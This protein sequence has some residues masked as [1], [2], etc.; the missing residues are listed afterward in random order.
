MRFRACM[1]IVVLAGLIV[2]SAGLL[3]AHHSIANFW[4]QDK[5]ISISGVVT[6]VKLVN[7][8]PEL[9]IDVTEGGQ[10]VQYVAFLRAG[11]AGL[12]KLGLDKAAFAPGT[13][14][15]LDGHPPKAGKGKGIFVEALTLGS[16]K[17][18]KLVEDGAAAQP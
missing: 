4:D 16:A 11:L 3:E 6:V 9:K 2:V 17:K 18:I 8:H 10:K 5:N 7:P 1:W 14:I 12:N 13:K 15:T